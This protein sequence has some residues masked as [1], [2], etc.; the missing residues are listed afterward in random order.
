MT[1]LKGSTTSQTKIKWSHEAIQA[2]ED[3]KTLLKYAIP[4]SFASLTLSL[5]IYSDSS[6]Q[7]IAGCIIQTDNNIARFG[8]FSHSLKN[9]EQKYSKFSKELL[10]LTLTVIQ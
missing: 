5:A 6:Q 7:S 2:F 3:A 4:I 8:Y 9:V 10:A 1:Y